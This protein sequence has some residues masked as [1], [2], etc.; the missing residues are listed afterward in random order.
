MNDEELNAWAETLEFLSDVETM[1]AIHKAN[2]ELANS[3]MF[4]FEQVFDR[5]QPDPPQ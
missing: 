3:E 2:E 1:Q 5:A 4:S